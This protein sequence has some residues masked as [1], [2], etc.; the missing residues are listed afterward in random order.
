[1]TL[2]RLEPAALRSRVKHS[3]TESSLSV[4]EK[5]KFK[6]GGCRLSPTSEIVPVCLNPSIFSSHYFVVMRFLEKYILF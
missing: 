6:R 2:V 1:M 4:V 3:T 5:F